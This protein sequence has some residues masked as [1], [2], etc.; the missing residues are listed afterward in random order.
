MVR[1]PF[2]IVEIGVRLSDEKAEVAH[3][4]SALVRPSVHTPGRRIAAGPP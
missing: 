1:H 3:L 4:S 2:K